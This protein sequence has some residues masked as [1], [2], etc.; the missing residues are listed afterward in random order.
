MTEG[1]QYFA[2]RTDDTAVLWKRLQRHGAATGLDLSR[3]DRVNRCMRIRMGLEKPHYAD[4][5]QRP[6]FY[7]PGLRSAPW[8]DRNQ[9]DWVESLEQSHAAIAR[10]G[11]DLQ[12]SGALEK[13]PE[14][15]GG[16]WA[17]GYLFFLGEKSSDLCQRCP[18]TT[19][20]VESIP[21]A[22]S[23]GLVYFASLA[24]GTHLEPHCGP[25]NARL[26]CHLGLRVPDGC[27][28]RVGAET[29]CWQEGKCIIFDD[30]FEHEVW[31]M[32]TEVRL[33]FVLDIW[34][35]D[36]NGEEIAAISTLM[37]SFAARP[38]MR[39]SLR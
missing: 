1:S 5:L 30:S 38:G 9:F 25:T 33:V 29:R 17:T 3:L 24:P 7:I 22:T 31:H 34:H 26:R 36:L 19:R 27:S 11:F 23:A 14:G 6:E 12:C 35:P 32:G 21:G 13:R 28:I 15:R 10:E 20:L 4:P 16:R 39:A 37:S 18:E 2:S 8:Y